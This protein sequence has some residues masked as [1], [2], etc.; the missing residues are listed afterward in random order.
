MNLIEE[1]GSWAELFPRL[2][3]FVQRPE[4]QK[5]GQTRARLSGRWP[6]FK[7]DKETVGISLFLM[8]ESGL[9]KKV[10]RLEKPHERE[11]N[12][13]RMEAIIASMC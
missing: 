10:G 11:A 3:A 2:E 8:Y 12:R 13:L 9:W 4:L 7:E 1:R 6:E 5:H